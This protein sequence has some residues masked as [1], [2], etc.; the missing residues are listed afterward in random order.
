MVTVANDSEPGRLGLRYL[1][2]A[3]RVR[4]VVDK[5]MVTSGLSLARW[6]V[7]EILDAKGSIR[8]K[9]LAQELGFAERSITQAVESLASD[10]LVERTP[11]PADGR[12]KLV[13]LTDEG[14]AALA[15]GTKAGAKVLQR[16]FGT[17]DRKQLEGLDELLNV[18]DDAEGG[19]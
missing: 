10:G 8:Q 6:K 1:T 2:L 12:A 13:T 5:H 4:K 11:D 19:N 17:V 18:I 7:L 16:I 3:Y 9:A 15:A 14:A